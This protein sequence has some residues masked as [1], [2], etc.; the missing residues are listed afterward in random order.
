MAKQ[1]GLHQIRGKVGE[2]SYYKQ[3]GVASGLIRSI[4]QGM[5][6]RVKTSEEYANVRLNNAE[7]GQAGRIA[8]VLG[9]YINP[10]YRPMILP[11]SQSKMCKAIL[12]SIKSDISQW[13]ERNLPPD[14]GALSCINALNSVA[15]NDFDSYGLA[16]SNDGS[17]YVVSS[18]EQYVEKLRAIGADG[19]NI[20]IV[21]ACPWIGTYVSSDNKYAES[22]TRALSI[23]G[24]M[25]GDS[26]E[27][28]IPEG[29]RPQPPSGW[30]AFQLEFIVVIVLPYRTVSDNDYTLQ[31][32]CTYR[33]F[34]VPTVPQP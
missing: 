17:N 9:R 16:L 11:F 5:S 31:E 14:T 7:F 8:K 28:S 26:D 10:K 23:N 30:P 13:G 18:S 25:T 22:F 6:E 24:T 20:I 1:S 34:E 21:N 29:F 27:V 19:A 2:H 15:K 4:N 3:T 12:E 33:A 32:H